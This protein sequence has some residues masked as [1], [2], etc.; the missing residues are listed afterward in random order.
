[1]RTSR[2]YGAR[3]TIEDFPLNRSS[4]IRLGLSLSRP[5]PLILATKS[6]LRAITDKRAAAFATWVKHEDFLEPVWSWG[7]RITCGS[8]T[9]AE[10]VLEGR[11]SLHDEVIAPMLAQHS[12]QLSNADIG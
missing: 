8:K 9:N 10:G 12:H 7:Q 4:E 3:E 2:R 6:S 5:R 11:S 1:M